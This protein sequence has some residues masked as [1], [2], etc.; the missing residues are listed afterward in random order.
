MFLSSIVRRLF[1]MATAM[2]AWFCFDAAVGCRE[3]REQQEEKRNRGDVQR[4][5]E[6]TVDERRAATGERAGRH[7]APE[8]VA[9]FEPREP[10]LEQSADKDEREHAADRSGVGDDLQVIVVRL[11]K[12]HG[13]VQRIVARVSDAERAET[14]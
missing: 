1:A 3:R 8:F 13:T 11:L 4:E 2:R 7:A 14:C 5:I 12:P 10:L 9:R 6:K